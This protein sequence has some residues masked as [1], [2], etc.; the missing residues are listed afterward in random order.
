MKRTDALDLV[1]VDDN[2]VLVSVLS[3]IFAE[4]GHNVRAASNGFLALAAIRNRVPDI[5]I[6]D[7]SLQGTSGYQLLS[8]VRSR[9]PSIRVIAMSRGYSGGGI[10]PDVAADAFYA[11]GASSVAHLIETVRTVWRD[12]ICSPRPLTLSCV[13]ECSADRSDGS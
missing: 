10:P 13:L 6:S 7:L 8:V 2:P 12:G 1:V 5:L 3:Q 9:F 4:C 11:K